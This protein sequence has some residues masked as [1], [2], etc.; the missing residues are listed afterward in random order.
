MLDLFN[1]QYDRET[2][3]K[4]IYST[5]LLDI[6]KTQKIDVTFAVRYL[7]NPNYHLHDE[8]SMITPELIIQLQPH[9][10]M[11]ELRREILNYDNDDDSVDG[12]D[13]YLNK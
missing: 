12:F 5:N 8:Y 11:K 4:H 6:L 10:K 1:V 2:L 7:L 9:I 3:K 13:K